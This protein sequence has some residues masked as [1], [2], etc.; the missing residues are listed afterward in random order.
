MA[1]GLLAKGLMGA[2][3]AVSGVKMAKNIFK[4][5]GGKDAPDV[6]A[7]EQIV[8]VQAETVQPITPLVPTI[9]PIDATGISK[10]TSPTG[11]ED[12]VGTAFRI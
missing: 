5:K 11:T 9:N 4:R 7:S 3:K 12:L 10:A 1:L 2:G 6:P 8:D